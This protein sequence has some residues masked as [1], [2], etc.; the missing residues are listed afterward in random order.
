MAALLRVDPAQRLSAL[1]LLRQPWVCGVSAERS[2]SASADAQSV[3]CRRAAISLAARAGG[4]RHSAPAPSVCREELG[5]G[6]GAIAESPGGESGER[7]A[8]ALRTLQL[9]RK[10]SDLCC[11]APANGA[12]HEHP[13]A[14]PLKLYLRSVFM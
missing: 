14:K 2:S 9:L 10:G 8:R 12:P 7:L 1:A 6:F 11:A 4:R 5:L 13:F 3:P